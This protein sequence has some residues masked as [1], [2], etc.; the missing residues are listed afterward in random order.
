MLA[1]ALLLPAF[2]RLLASYEIRIKGLSDANSICFEAF[3]FTGW[4]TSNFN[5]TCRVLEGGG[6]GIGTN[7]AVPQ[8]DYQQSIPQSGVLLLLGTVRLWT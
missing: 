3:K 6:Y 7:E 2:G 1:A 5:T 8:Q 4:T